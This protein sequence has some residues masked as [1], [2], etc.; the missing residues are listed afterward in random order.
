MDSVNHKSRI[1]NSIRNSFLGITV[2]VTNVLLGFIVRSV[3]IRCLNAEYLGVNGLFSNILTMLS[4]AEMG[5]GSAIIYNMYKPIADDDE[6]Q[7]AKLMNFYRQAYIC[8]GCVV[9]AIGL[10]ITPFLKILINNQSNISNLTIIYLLYLS[11]TV[12]S[13]FFAYKRSI[14]SADQRES[15]LHIFRLIFYVIR[16]VLQIAC[17]L[18]LHN[19]IIY[20]IIQIACTFF[21]NIFVSLYAD[22]EYPFFN[23]CKRV[24]LTKQ[25]KKPIIENV[26]ALFIYK[27]G[28]TALD[29][30]DNIII[31]AF[32][33]II[34]VGIYSNYTLITNSVQ[35]LLSQV[36]NSLSGSVGNF[37]AKEK[38]SRFEKL[39]KRITFLNFVIY[40]GAFVVLI[41]CL[42]PFIELWAGKTYMLSF[43][44]VFVHCLNLYI[45]GMMNSIW[46][47]RSA[48]GLFVYGKWRPLVSAVINIITSIWWGNYWGILGVLLGTTFARIITNVWFDPY[49]V[50]KHGLKKS[51]RNYYKQ[52]LGYFSIILI[53][54]FIIRL[55]NEWV[56]FTGLGL[57]AFNVILSPVLFISTLIIF[58]RKTSDFKYFLDIV[59]NIVINQS[60]NH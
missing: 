25:E 55:I 29:G 36:S 53:L 21:E 60:K 47:F 42:S 11:N 4:L 20:L 27:I 14:F 57:L 3:F 40:G 12:F 35:L 17:L 45:Y 13:Y 6:I 26:K 22:K 8:I 54:T 28:S 33:G 31:T 23:K 34:N 18:L 59:K 56:Q 44:V 49:I 37:V 16:S 39:L 41:A 19:F 5:V 43:E 2:Q 9:A 32:D 15:V 52:W 7:I 30:T 51:P 48:M 38:E 46:T 24:R 58:F 10:C 1:E 50:Y